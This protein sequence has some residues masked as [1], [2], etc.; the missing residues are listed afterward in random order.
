MGKPRKLTKHT[1]PRHVRALRKQCGHMAHAYS[2]GGMP[3]AR[4]RKGGFRTLLR[5]I[6]DQ[7]ISVYA[8]AAI[9]AKL[10][11]RLTDITAARVLAVQEHTLQACGLSGQKIRY[12]RELAKAI[13]SGDLDLEALHK[14]DD[15]TAAAQLTQVKGV[16]TWTAEIYLMFAMGRP[17]I[18]PA[19][20]LAIQ[21]AAQNLMG[22]K[23]RPSIKE[24][25]V[26]AERWAPY[27]TAAAIMLWQFY[28]KMPL[29]EQAAD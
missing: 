4:D 7:Q 6:I 22:L 29:M 20:D 25:R 8:G 3:P 12:A 16:G 19:G 2:V 9:W 13:H 27:R 24:L 11:K 26:I 17:D 21:V 1:M 28:R 15:D 23:E 5:I 10:E 14:F 18:M